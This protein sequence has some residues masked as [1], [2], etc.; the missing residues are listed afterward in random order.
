MNSGGETLRVAIADDHELF[1]QGLRGMLEEAGMEVV[2]EA[3]DGTD[4]VALARELRPDV[5]VL[6]LN[7]PGT[8]GIQALRQIA[9]NCPDVQ[10]VVLTV[11]V[12]EDDVLEALAGGACGY[13]LK[14]TSPR[15]LAEG[16]RQAADGQALLSREV[17][18]ALA[19]RVRADAEVRTADARAAAQAAARPAAPGAGRS[20]AG[21]STAPAGAGS[22][23]QPA[24]TQREREVLHLIVAGE[25]NVAIGKALSISPHTVKQHVTNI[26]EKLEVSSRVQAAVHAVRA[27]L[28]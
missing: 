5:V 7:M 10:T 28:V 19:E 25:D 27:G 2:G 3:C 6:D 14:D 12:A 21:G 23:A 11:S 26:F 15:R 1:R 22:H 18:R 20:T 9:R 13:L 16:I 24:L 8:S 17:A 4:A